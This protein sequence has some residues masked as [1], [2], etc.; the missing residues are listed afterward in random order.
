MSG[1]V[2]RGKSYSL[3]RGRCARIKFDLAA[4]YVVH[5]ARDLQLVFMDELAKY[6][7]LFRCVR[8]L[9][10]YVLFNGFGKDIL[11][12]F[13]FLPGFFHRRGYLCHESIDVFRGVTAFD[14]RFY[15]AAFGVAQYDKKGNMEVF[16][17]VFNAAQDDRV[18]YVSCDADDEYPAEGS[19]KKLRRTLNRSM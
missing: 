13:S 15:R 17:R 3:M 14:S 5:G 4:V 19:R 1:E 12:V 18:G 10:V 6:R 8:D 7:A 16:G 9:K 2:G 11:L